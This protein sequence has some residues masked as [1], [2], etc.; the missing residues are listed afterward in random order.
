MR[1]YLAL[2]FCCRVFPVYICHFEKNSTKTIVFFLY[3]CAKA[4]TVEEDLPRAPA[5]LQRP[6]QYGKKNGIKIGSNGFDQIRL[7]WI[8]PTLPYA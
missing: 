4:A 8:Q 7:I 2:A 6:G 3:A 5:A 1:L